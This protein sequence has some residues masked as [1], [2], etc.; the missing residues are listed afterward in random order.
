MASFH[1]CQCCSLILRAANSLSSAA[2]RPFMSTLFLVELW[3]TL[4]ECRLF[5]KQIQ[6]AFMMRLTR[7]LH[8]LYCS[9]RSYY[10]ASV[11]GGIL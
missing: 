3:S 11:L 9:N 2:T 6:L 10:A 5:Q 4:V 7:H 1:D 8:K